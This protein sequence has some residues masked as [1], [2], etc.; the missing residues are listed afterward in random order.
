MKKIFKFVSICI[1]HSMEI[2]Q[3]KPLRLEH[4][5]RTRKSKTI[6]QTCLKLIIGHTILLAA[7]DIIFLIPELLAYPVFTY[8]SKETARILNCRPLENATYRNM[9]C[10]RINDLQDARIKDAALSE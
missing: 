6:E 9:E 7:A 8:L 5:L 3:G 10:S 2:L 4:L 1:P